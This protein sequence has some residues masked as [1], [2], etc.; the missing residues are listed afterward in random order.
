MTSENAKKILILSAGVGAGH[1]ITAKA[2]V[3]ACEMSHPEAK[4]AWLD[5]LELSARVYKWFCDKLINTTI[6]GKM[7]H[8]YSYIYDSLD[9]EEKMVKR[10][11][12]GTLVSRF[13]SRKFLRRVAEEKPDIIICT[14]FQPGD[15]IHSLR[16]KG[17]ITCPVGV[18]VTDYYMHSF[19]E[20]RDADFFIVSSDEMKAILAEKGYA[21]EKIHVIGIPVRPEFAAPMDR[22]AILKKLNCTDGTPIVMTIASGWQKRGAEVAVEALMHTGIKMQI[23]AVAGKNKKSEAKLRTLTPPPGVDLKVFGFVDYVHEMMSVADI[24]VAKPGG[25]TMVEAL[26]VGLP[27]LAINPV[28][29]QEMGNCHYLQQAGAGVLVKRLGCLKYHLHEILENREKRE[30]MRAAAKNAG[31]PRAAFEIIDLLLSK[32]QPRE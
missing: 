8:L 19:W 31:N 29:G 12:I 13:L 28:P 24:L 20:V 26:A 18:V 22:A 30:Q 1:T 25:V 4:A 11:T 10:D 21:P 32:L 27:M 7:P 3:K 9:K 14:H 15:I 17:R 5:S 16:R 23:L 2:L 6:A